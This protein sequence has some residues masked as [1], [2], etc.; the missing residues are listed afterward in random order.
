MVEGSARLHRVRSEPEEGEIVPFVA[1]MLGSS[2]PTTTFEFW[3]TYL[4]GS[5]GEAPVTFN[6]AG[7]LSRLAGVVAIGQTGYST[8]H[9]QTIAC[10]RW[11]LA[12]TDSPSDCSLERQE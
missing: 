3:T 2:E 8:T 6:A 10:E 9:P 1:P 4:L 11:I 5:G 12:G 7:A